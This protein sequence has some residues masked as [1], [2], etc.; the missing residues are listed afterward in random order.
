MML[1]RHVTSNI[2]LLECNSMKLKAPMLSESAL[3]DNIVEEYEVMSKPCISVAHVSFQMFREGGI[4]IDVIVRSAIYLAEQNHQRE[5]WNSSGLLN[6][7]T[8]VNI[9][10]FEGSEKEFEIL[11]LFLESTPKLIRLNVLSDNEAKHQEILEKILAFKL[12]SPIAV[13][14][15]HS[16]LDSS[17]GTI[18]FTSTPTYLDNLLMS[19]VYVDEN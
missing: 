6:H 14:E 13:I 8:L 15:F 19:I 4:R 2:K 5:R 1:A 7:L 18:S 3:V 10:R 16:I 9:H 17:K 11:R 12:S